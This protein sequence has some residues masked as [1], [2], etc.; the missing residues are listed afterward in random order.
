MAIFRYGYE[1]E[2]RQNPYIGFTSFQHFRDDALYSDLVV[3]PE[4]NLTETEHVEC[5]PVPAYVEE[6]GRE[7]GYYPECSVV[8]IRILWKEFEPTEG[9]YRYAFIE[10][11][12][13]KARASKQTVMFRLMPHS[14]RE[15]DD[16]PDWLKDKISCPRRP[17]GQR[18]KRS[19]S[20]PAFLKY[21]GRAIR[22]FG[23]HFDADPA[24]SMV[25]ISLPGAWGEGSSVKLFEKDALESFVDIYTDVFKNTRLIGQ[26]SVPSLMQYLDGHTAVGFRADCLGKPS[27]LNEMLPPW[28][29]EMGDIWKRGHV[30]FESFWWLG[31]WQRQDW[32]VDA[33][34][35][36]TLSWHVSTFNAKSLPIPWE[37]RDKVDA[38]V[39]KMGYHFVIDEVEV[40]GTVARGKELS[41][42]LALENVGVA[43]I[44]HRLPLYVR[45][46]GQGIER[47]FE[48]E[49]DIRAW[50]PGKHEEC[51]SA[52]VPADIP[53]GTY[54]VQIGIGE[55]AA[56]VVFAT[57]AP[58]DRDAAVVASVD[59]I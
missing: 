24:L 3:K 16:V 21:F 31:E 44:Y 1:R 25:D 26:C 10:D 54:E 8:Y 45:L 4:N 35:E 37:W 48:M 52:L 38:W 51:L 5:Y 49:T 57:N 58:Q 34:I 43:P 18:V 56:S 7:Q 46:K 55:G 19:P 50:L 17:E 6:K 39:D 29:E 15:S 28:V 13:K 23:E 30:S 36:K 27:L 40:S 47:V 14:T 2:K 22:A 11:I 59:V 41:L 53:C 32:D 12:L 9:E 20:D 42:R 33:V